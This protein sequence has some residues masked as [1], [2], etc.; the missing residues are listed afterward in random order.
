MSRPTFEYDLNTLATR[1]PDPEMDTS[2]GEHVCT[3]REPA[4]LP[5]VECAA[6]LDPMLPGLH[7]A[8]FA[9]MVAVATP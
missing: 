4:V 7:I 6:L 3:Y 8:W 9:S 1:G 5:E 2:R